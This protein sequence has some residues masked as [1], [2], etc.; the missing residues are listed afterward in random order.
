MVRVAGCG[1]VASMLTAGGAAASCGAGSPTPLSEQWAA[2][3]I[4]SGHAHLTIYTGPVDHGA[5]LQ[6]AAGIDKSLWVTEVTLGAIMKFGLTGKAEIYA[7]P[8]SGSNP[9]AIALNG[10]S[11]YFTEWTTPCTG[12]INAKGQI[13]EYATPLG[14]TQ[15]TGM[16]AGSDGAAWFVTDYSG[17]GR[18]TAKGKDKQYYFGDDSAQPTAITLGPDKNIWFIENQGDYVGKITPAGVVTEYNVNTGGG[19]YSFGITAG[20][21][22]RIWF[23]DA[24]N[25]R[26][27]A[28]N[29]DGT[30]LTYYAAGLTGTPISIVGGPD[31]N[32]YFGETS[33]AV[34]RITTA[35]VISEYAFKPTLSSFPILSIVVGPDKNIWFSNNG[36]AQV[37]MLK[38]PVK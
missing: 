20:S 13:K 15:S 10:K 4:V 8:T 7:T 14:E 5:Q 19:S 24:H 37:G 11:M 16:I 2:Q 3:K 26:I 21:D 25:K 34:G 18:V 29:T 12:S 36:H 22:G 6:L 30:G 33:A 17:I 38:L 1:F 27:G 23:A 9:E 31:G 28:I 32:L 35:G